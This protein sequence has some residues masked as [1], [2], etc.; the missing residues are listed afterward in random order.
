MKVYDF[1]FVFSTTHVIDLRTI[2]CLLS[3]L[4]FFPHMPMSSDT[5][6]ESINLGEK[7]REACLLAYLRVCL[8]WLQQSTAV[9]ACVV[10][11]CFFRSF[12]QARSDRVG[13]LDLKQYIYHR[14][15]TYQ[16]VLKFQNVRC[17][18][19]MI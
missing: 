3:L 16:K 14:S 8:F 2:A 7:K 6:R 5:H 15:K 11:F 17:H 9:I 19:L 4:T 12:S 18:I 13:V 1:C 10:M